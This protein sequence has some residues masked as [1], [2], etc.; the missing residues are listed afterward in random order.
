MRFEEAI[1]MA[2]RKHAFLILVHEDEEMFRR[3]VGRVSNIGPVF[4]HVD[5]K[6]HKWRCNDVSCTFTKDRIPV[7]WGDWSIVQATV[8]LLEAAL[9]DSSITRFTLLSG[10]HY[11][12]VSNQEIIDEAKRPGNIIAARR[13]P[14]MPDGT[15]PE[16]EYERRFY[17][18]K[19][20]HGLWDQTKNGFMNRI[21]YY[22]RPLDWKVVT[23]HSGMR[24]GSQFWSLERDFAEYCVDQIHSSRPLIDY[25]RRITCSDEKVFGT[26]FGEFSD[27]VA[28]EGTTFARWSQGPNPSPLFR[29]DIEEAILRDQFWFARKFKSS[30]SPILDWL[31]TM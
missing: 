22:G 18:T 19:R 9:G 7:Y 31:D 15:R 20:P 23:P 26:L 1:F 24:A 6:T 17:R 21:I 10:S 11:P 2:E 16:V 29:T 3:L 4:V 8:S 28:I 30:D 14:N 25:F 5:A 13:A 27:Q 12:I